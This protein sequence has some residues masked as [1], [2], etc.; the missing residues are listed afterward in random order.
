MKKLAITCCV[1]LLSASVASANFYDIKESNEFADAINYVKTAGY[2]NG[3][4]DMSYKPDNQI[5]RA[6]FT[7]IIVNTYFAE[8]AAQESCDNNAF[9]KV[10]SDIPTS[11]WFKPYIC[12]AY[13]HGVVTGYSDKTFRPDGKIN[14]AEAAKIIV[15]SFDPDGSKGYANKQSSTWYGAYVNALKD[16]NAEPLT[17]KSPGQLITR[18]E[19]AYMIWK[20]EGLGISPAEQL[21][22][23]QDN[24]SIILG[25]SLLKSKVYTPDEFVE[26]GFKDGNVYIAIKSVTCYNNSC[27]FEGGGKWGVGTDTKDSESFFPYAGQAVDMVI[28]ADQNCQSGA[29]ECYNIKNV[30]IVLKDSAA[31]YETTAPSSVTQFT[32]GT[33]PA[34]VKPTG[35]TSSIYVYFRGSSNNLREMFEYYLNVPDTGKWYGPFK[36]RLGGEMQ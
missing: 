20:F 10:F 1:L 25:T 2:V 6:E 18:G 8:A 29:E 23:V 24:A 5:N 21:R 34:D 35:A 13:D 11:T 30:S 7:K 4:P 36:G 26:G 12:S 28:K 16:R 15:K 27:A 14:Y 9:Q 33:T 32:Y 31:K 22:S 17:I 19:M 3:Y